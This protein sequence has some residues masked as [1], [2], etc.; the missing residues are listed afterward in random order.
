MRLVK[1]LRQNDH[2]QKF[3][4]RSRRIY[5]VA[6]ERNAEFFKRADHARVEDEGKR[7]TR[8]QRQPKSH[9]VSQHR[10]HQ[11]EHRQRWQ[12]VPEC[13][14]RMRSNALGVAG[15]MPRLRGNERVF[16]CCPSA[17]TIPFKANTKMRAATGCCCRAGRY[18]GPRNGNGVGAWVNGE[19]PCG[20]A[21]FLVASLHSINARRRWTAM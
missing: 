12:H 11:Q 3:I 13:R 1:F 15:I 18:S 19:S 16:S 5:C 20:H 7:T 2:A 8:R 10:R 17:V 14:L 6:S 9:S 21:P 4:C